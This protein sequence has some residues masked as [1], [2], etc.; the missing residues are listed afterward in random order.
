[1]TGNRLG[2]LPRH[3]AAA[4]IACFVFCTALSGAEI[5]LPLE[6]TAYFVG[7]LVPLAIDGGD[8][9]RLEAVSADGKTLL[10]EGPAKLLMVDTNRL[11]PATYRL[12]LDGADSQKDF[13]VVST[14][15]RSAG[16]MQ[17]EST[18][19]GP[20]FP[21]KPTLAQRA[22]LI[23]ENYKA[24]AKTL[25]DSGLTAVFLPA[26][27]DLK[28]T[29]WL[30]GAARAAV[31]VLAN[32]DTRPTSFFPVGSDP[33]ERDSMSQRIILGAQANGRYP[34]FGGYFF[35]WDTTGYAIG[36]RRGLLTYWGW[37]DKTAALRKYLAR[38]D[39]QSQDEFRRRT[40]MEPVSE[41]E[42]IA[43]LLSIKRPEFATAIDLPTRHWLDEI[44]QYSNPM[45]EPDRIAFEKRLDAW[46]A[47]LMGMYGEAYGVLAKNLREVDPQLKNS[48]SVQV[49]HAPVR[50]GQYFPSAY[51]PLDFQ[52][53]STWNDQVGGPDYSYQ[54]LFTAGLL[55]MQRGAKPTW[56]SNA[57][58]A[59]HDRADVPG[60]FTRVAA[61]GLSWG[62][63]GIGFAC[64]G[65][66]TLLGSMNKES[67]WPEIQG[68]AGQADV[69]GGREFLDRF[70][71]L[72]VEGTGDHGVGILFS[73]S[74]YQRQH[75]AMGFGASPYQA[76]V[77]LTRLGYTP[78]FVTE[79]ELVATGGKLKLQALLAIGQTFP[80]P[81]PVMEAI[82][83][84]AKQ[85][86]LVLV[87]GNSTVELPAQVKLDYAFSF[88]RPG[89]PHNWATPN[90]PA[91]DNDALM[92]ARWHDEIAPLLAKALGN[93]GRGLLGSEL[94]SRSKISLMQIDGGTDAKYV[95]AVN[96]SHQSTQADWHQVREKLVSTP[97]GVEGAK[98]DRAKSWFYDCTD[99]RA[100]GQ[101]GDV[102]CDLSNTTARVFA[103]L[104]REP[105]RIDLRASQ[106]I[107]AGSALNLNVRL[108]DAKDQPL[109]AVV[110][111]YLTVTRPD[112]K[113][114]LEV[115]RSTDRTG[116]F[117]L[118]LPMA[119][120]L[121]AGK[122]SVSVRCQLNGM[123]ATLPVS[124][125]KPAQN[126]QPPIAT[127]YTNAV[128]ARQA[129]AAEQALVKGAKFVL[130]IFDSPSADKLL[131]VAEKIKQVLAARG[132]EVEIRKQP[133]IGSYWLAYD[134]TEPQAAENA[135]VERGELIGRIKRETA[136]QND[137]FSALSGWRF[138]KPLILLDLANVP[139][140]NPMAESL[141]K[142]G[143]LWPTVTAA[144]PGA[145]RAVVEAA[146]WAFSPRATTIVIHSQ[147]IEGLLHGAESLAKLPADPLTARMEGVKQEL[148]RQ[149]YVGGKPAAADRPNLTAE[150][151]TAEGLTASSA[152]QP[153]A[154]HFP[155]K[156]PITADQVAAK[157]RPAQAAV[158]VP[159]KLEP[160][161]FVIFLRDGD[162]YIESA[163]AEMLVP[164]LR[165]SD[166]IQLTIDAPKAG[167]YRLL[168]N[169]VFRYNDRKPCWQAQW[170]DL[171]ELREKLV[172][173]QRRAMSID[174][175][176]DGKQAAKLASGRVETKEVAL[177]LASPSAGLKPKAAME[178]V[179][180]QLAGE[181]EL[182][183]GQHKLLLI[184]HN[185][186]DGKIE[187]IEIA[188]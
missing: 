116:R 118:E 14:I 102:A 185:I 174:V 110:P 89:K 56:L 126:A 36:N 53:Q 146:P 158:A 177:E 143:I 66:S 148:W 51:A 87:D 79:E 182:P 167:K 40:G 88:S 24:L 64:E 156:R 149:Y 180:T 115:Y 5:E 129:G 95:V 7:E 131:P 96:D 74:Q 139:A 60:K 54:W 140:A 152:P 113:P 183:A 68:K 2:A 90:M 97:G 33:A 3:C 59:V 109:Q 4:I 38:I 184:H 119:V 10:Y 82:G 55:D 162:K 42:Y 176:L 106:K 13:I 30:D 32:P 22:A 107:A 75:I 142:E 85:G 49:D 133:E 47:Y 160:K 83:S 25:K 188:E 138:S 81:A 145:G 154:I 168:V 181:V 67:T 141:A 172:P 99:E 112:G 170:E 80:L 166:A 164:D 8:S 43:Y 134:L 101:R 161:Q 26:Q 17:D 178:E 175:R 165:F 111:F 58:G 39:Q 157:A 37:G 50:Y 114:L 150:G 186:V 11:A 86:G 23:E 92:M 121:P 46:S 73:K 52:Y 105:A 71:C 93:R 57:F 41:A 27:S 16:S 132:V 69:A 135:R 61:H 28:Q 62:V 159:G 19:P 12:H 70:A 45:S 137:W 78:R 31:L 117:G 18:P 187:H 120:N 124:V 173:K 100:L 128:L 144:F 153:F 35:G 20:T 98:D 91:G 21:D 130:P 171:I 147:D 63:S 77:L 29:E 72:A 179:V 6:R 94:G 136:N 125:E 9:H 108:V 163:T 127:A 104:R 65:F 123:T 15:K 122:W 169:G 34:N 1:M 155:D 84:F 103:I 151:L 44:S 76:F 48:A